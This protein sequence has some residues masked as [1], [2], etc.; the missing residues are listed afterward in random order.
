M[1]A[2]DPVSS[3][4]PVVAS[5]SPPRGMFQA[6]WM[7][8]ASS[9]TPLSEDATS[10]AVPARAGAVSVSHQL[11][12]ARGTPI[13]SHMS[14]QPVLGSVFKTLVNSLIAH[15]L[16]LQSA[17]SRKPVPVLFEHIRHYSPSHCSARRHGGLITHHS[18][19]PIHSTLPPDQN[20]LLLRYRPQ[21]R[22]HRRRRN[23]DHSQRARRVS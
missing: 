13:L 5:S 16:L 20:R 15:L 22:Q 11:P 6:P 18:F 3:P 9:L 12:P 2:R 14:S 8:F 21:R 23:Q 4:R 17:I 1:P 19:I 10:S 7:S